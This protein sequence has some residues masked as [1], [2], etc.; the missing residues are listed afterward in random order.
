MQPVENVRKFIEEENGK[1]HMSKEEFTAQILELEKSLYYVSKSIL[2][3]DEDCKDAMQN[4]ILKAYKNLGNLRAEKFFKTWITR[5]LINE[6]YEIAKKNKR[7]VSYEEYMDD[8]SE[9]ELLQLIDFYHKVSYSVHTIGTEIVEG[10]TEGNAAYD[11]DYQQLA[12]ESNGDSVI[13]YEGSVGVICAAEGKECLYLAGKNVIERIA[14]GESNS[15]PFYA[16]DFGENTVVQ[17][18]EEDLEQGLYVLLLSKDAS[19]Y[20]GSKVL[21]LGK[22]GELLY[23][24]ALPE[25]AAYDL[26]VDG[27][28]RLYLETFR[29]IYV[30]DEAGAEVCG[31][32]IP[33]SLQNGNLCRGKDGRMYTLCEEVS[34][35]TS[36]LCL[37]PDAE[38][39]VKLVA[40]DGLPTGSPRCSNIARGKETDFILWR[41][42]G[43]YTYNLGDTLVHKVME[44]YEAPLPWEGAHFATLEDGRAVFVKYF[45]AEFVEGEVVEILPVPESVRI[46]YAN[47]SKTT[48]DNKE[49]FVR[50]NE[51]ILGYKIDALTHFTQLYYRGYGEV[52]RNVSSFMVEDINGQQKVIWSEG[53]VADPMD[54][55]LIKEKG[56]S[57]VTLWDRL[58]AEA[59]WTEG[60][61]DC[62]CDYWI[63]LGDVQVGYHS[64]CGV[65]TDSAAGKMFEI[66]E[67]DKELVNMVLEHYFFEDRQ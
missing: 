15:T 59:D 42:D 32:E 21:H 34:F 20:T 5:I 31:W 53:A 54:M 62:A 33:Y 41:D 37:D 47:L 28:G 36:L 7:Q 49:V 18:M 24:K 9:E 2:C 16:A 52:F 44:V 55:Y 35:Q 38:E 29:E 57:G 63:T 60:T 11:H 61:P 50:S 3:N 14:F 23:E 22:D 13:A 51:T 58:L 43:V 19:G 27:A 64:E 56:T 26:A 30:Y 1:G 17:A 48:E 8:L 10:N 25:C 46:C 45:D 65:I 6:C 66:S 67:N 12:P 4:A 40:G 39:Q